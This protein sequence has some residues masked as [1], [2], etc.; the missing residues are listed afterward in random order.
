MQIELASLEGSD[1]GFAHT[2]EPGQLALN[3]DRVHLSHPLTVRGRVRQLGGK[4][5]VQGQVNAEVEIDCDRCLKFVQTPIDTNFTVEYVTP[6]TYQASAGAELSESDMAVSIFDGEAIDVDELV[7]EQVL[8]VV[9]SRVLCH[10]SCKGLCP[11]C[12]N[13]RNQSNCNCET[14]EVDPRWGALKELIN[15]K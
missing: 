10:E 8:L 1:G 15:G 3:D 12:G 14:V 4:V 2:Y 11:M 5:E 9:P 13:D 7:S 6:Q